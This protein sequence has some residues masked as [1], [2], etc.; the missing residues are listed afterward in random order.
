MQLL[1][2]QAENLIATFH[3]KLLAMS[4]GTI[5][6]II[7]LAVKYHLCPRPYY[8]MWEKTIGHTA[9]S[10]NRPVNNYYVYIDLLFNE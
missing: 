9:L 6:R 1:I 8:K 5:F 2:I 3:T 4:D 7:K 10:H